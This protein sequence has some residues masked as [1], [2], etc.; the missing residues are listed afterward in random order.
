MLQH[1]DMCCR[2]LGWTL[3][4]VLIVPN[5]EAKACLIPLTEEIESI[6][7]MTLGEMGVVEL[8]QGRHEPVGFVSTI[9]F[10]GILAR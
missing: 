3:W 2:H 9:R 6:L 5:Q 7:P 1:K 8:L 10:T 4:V